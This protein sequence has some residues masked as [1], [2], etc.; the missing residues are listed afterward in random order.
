MVLGRK[1]KCTFNH[2]L[3]ILCD[4]AACKISCIY[5]VLLHATNMLIW[6]GCKQRNDPC[7]FH[8]KM[9]QNYIDQGYFIIKISQCGNKTVNQGYYYIK[10][11]YARYHHV[12]CVCQNGITDWLMHSKCQNSIHHT[13]MVLGSNIHNMCMLDA[14]FYGQ[15]YPSSSY[16]VAGEEPK[17]HRMSI[18]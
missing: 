10:S 16:S 11:A 15:N 2:H 1:C 8:C 5:L 7:W 3:P 17:I 13:V 12:Q 9:P 4:T 14:L 18:Y 6:S